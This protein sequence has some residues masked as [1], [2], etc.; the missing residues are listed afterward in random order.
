[1]K[2]ISQQGNIQKMVVVDHIPEEE[3]ELI[4]MFRGTI[5]KITDA[6]KE[7]SEVTVLTEKHI[8]KAGF[9]IK[10]FKT[11]SKVLETI[12]VQVVKP[13]NDEIKKINVAFKFFKSLYQSEEVRLIAEVESVYKQIKDAQELQRKKEQKEHDDALIEEA[14]LFD[15]EEVLETKQTIVIK[16]TKVSDTTTHIKSVRKKEWRVVDLTK[17]PPHYLMISDQAINAERMQ[18]DF[19]AKSTIDGIEFYFSEKVTG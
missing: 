6:I 1:M 18:Q 8:D 7:S 14:I 9:Y 13:K 3:K 17:V 10:H 2:N 16:K 19:D 15:D 11:L 12:R 5:S 4:T